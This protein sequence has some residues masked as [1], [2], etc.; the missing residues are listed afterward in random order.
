MPIRSTSI[1]AVGT[2]EQSTNSCTVIE[3]IVFDSA[4]DRGGEALEHEARVLARRVEARTRFADAATMRDSSSSLRT[5]AG[6]C[7]TWW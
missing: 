7:T 5:S 3:S 2:L 6:G 4:G 1:S